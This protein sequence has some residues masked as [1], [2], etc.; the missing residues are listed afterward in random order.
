MRL[1]ISK[2][3]RNGLRVLLLLT[4]LIPTVASAADAP[5]GGDVGVERPCDPVLS[6]LLRDV[7]AR[8]PVIV[9]SRAMAAAAAEV[10]AQAR[11]LPDPMLQL[12]TTMSRGDW[13][14]S[15]DVEVMAMQTLPPK[16]QRGLMGQ[17]ALADAAAAS[18][19]ADAARIEALADTRRLYYEIAYL[20]AA[21][22]LRR[23]QRDAVRDF[24][25][26]ARSRYETGAGLMA[27]VT[28]TSADVTRMDAELVDLHGR[29][30]ATL[31]ALNA[32]RGQPSDAPISPSRLPVA[33]RPTIDLDALR[34]SA[35]ERRP[36]VIEASALEDA[37]KARVEMALRAG[38]PDVTVGGWYEAMDLG[39]RSGDPDEV[40]FVVGITIPRRGRVAAGLA[41]ARQRE[42]A[43]SA[44][45]AVKDAVV[46]REIGEAVAQL[47]T[48]HRQADIQ[49][50]FLAVQAEDVT[51]STLSG[52]ST[53]TATAFEVL[54]SL[55]AKFE[56]Q[57]LELRSRVDAL[58]AET[59]LA[60]ATAAPELGPCDQPALQ[61]VRKPSREMPT[62]ITPPTP[63]P[64]ARPR[65]RLGR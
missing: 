2:R 6:D 21:K 45:R 32:L 3:I 54:D 64:P 58:Q 36:D 28:R 5:E 56:V 25:A 59:A 19:S 39:S 52:Y 47:D 31:A 38:R 12:R 1:A 51:R 16:G 15:T 8:S 42:L 18:A 49:H 23:Q 9:A 43:A 34:A 37:A 14:H 40:G 11:S 48:A 44:Q 30:T 46:E 41:Q 35:L 26:I 22:Q 65:A 60:A 24:V 33:A 63:R 50:D 20:D 29:R 57:L 4:P 10:P 27:D 7:L 61:P 17:A 53:G 62:S 55:R 13:S